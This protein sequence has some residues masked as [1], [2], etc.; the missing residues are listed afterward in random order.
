MYKKVELKDGFVGMEH[1]VAENWKEKDIIKKNFNMNEGK[2]YFTFYDGP[3]TANGKPHVG[4]IE[5]RVMKDIIP[6]YKVMKGYKVIRKAGW[7][8]HGLPVELEIEKSLGISGKEQIEEYGVEKFVKKC[9][10]SVFTYVHMWEEM[11]NKV[12]YWVDMENP[13]VTYH[14]DYIES[15]WWALK[16]MW[17]KGLLYEG[18]KVMPYCPR[19]GTA[20]SSHEVA[21][22]YK[23]VKDLTC[24]AKFKVV[25]KENTYILAW[26]TT[27]W[28]LPSNL[29]LCVNKS[30]EYA[31]VKA[32]VGTDDEPKYENY[33][34]AKDLIETVL[35]ETPYEIIKTF[36]GEELLGTK[37]E[38]LMPFAKVEGKAFEVIH[39]DYVTLT[40]GTGIVHIAPAYGED[41][42]LVSKKNGIAFVNLVD[43]SG[44]FV[45]EV[46]PWA[47][48]FVRDCN[49]D[50]CKWLADENKLF[51][52][53][54]HIHSYPHCWR[55]DT[56]LLYYPKESWFVAMSKLRGELV[57]NNST[58]N[59]YPETIKTGRFGKFLENVIDWGISRDRYWGT[60]LPVWTCEDEN[61]GHQECI[62]S[63]EELKEKALE[64]PEDI[65][66]HK[67]YIDNVYL[68]CPK[69]GGKMKRAKEVIDCWFD[70][71]S[72]PF[73]QWHYPFENED[74]FKNNFPAGFISEAVDQTRGWFYTLMAIGTALFNKSPFENCIVLGHVLDEHGQKMSKSKKNGVDPMVL[75]DSVG[76]DA[77]RW[78]FYTC[79]SPWLPTRLGIKNVQETQRGF[80][81]TLWNVYSFYVLYAEID[82]FNPLQYASFKTEN[83]MDKWIISKLNT[84]VKE[85]D[86]KLAH[87]DITSAALQIE[88]FTDELS[89]WY[90]RRNRERFWSENLTDDKIGAYVTLYK[91]LTTLIKVAAPFV[92]FMTDEIYQNLVVGLDK[93][94]PESVHLCLWPEVDENAIN[95]ELEKE[96]DLAYKIVKLGRSARNSANIKNRQPLSEMLI[97]IDN[98]PQYYED[99]VKEELNV[100]KVELGA[101]M[102]QYVDFEIKPNLPVLGKEYGKLIPQIRTKLA[103]MNQMDLAT[104]VKNG[105]SEYI[106]IGDTQIELTADN[107]LVTMQG[108]EGFA[109]SG[110]GEIGVILETTITPELRKEGYVREVLSKVQNMRKDKGFEVLDNINLYVAG[111]EELEAVIKEN[112]ELIKHDILAKKV[113]YHEERDNYTTTNINGNNLDIDIEKV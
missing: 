8:T 34:L 11:T 96:M 52:K 56:P 13:Y 29:A 89:N 101:E 19:C 26:T 14:N 65:E 66:L 32:N 45:E 94:A 44:N 81:S 100:K 46:E 70:S 10:E 68:K 12:G 15:V 111:S 99:I 27:P 76:A 110:E 59:W 106:E 61:C 39:G 85:V 109:F 79:S 105:K 36:K 90:V 67:P 30:Y 73:A 88:G 7:D 28:T 6:R 102:S 72:M 60:P 41:D 112:E 82:Q 113:V 16:Q 9:K 63:I 31:E 21:Q 108:K 18:H 64:C 49:E 86:D 57:A 24:I 37:Y 4:H 83:I 3:P 74:M 92:P 47:G 91:V 103:E 20:L 42:S 95:K 87:Y 25:G 35:K 58:V 78:H 23:D 2:R 22:G 43:K 62:G 97:S 98:L 77:T 71:G 54:K 75:L 107:L 38:Q 80:L 33:I 5:T 50:I 51:S 1:K 40:D 55:C 17:K 69:C 93:N 53:E 48:K 84:L 104:K